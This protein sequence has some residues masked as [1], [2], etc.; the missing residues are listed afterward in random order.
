M[1]NTS[2]YG[3]VAVNN[4]NE[5]VIFKN[6]APFTYCITEMNNTKID[7]AQKID[8]V[9]PMYDLIEYSDAYSKTSWS[10]RQHYRDETALNA[11]DEIIHFPAD[12]NNIASFKFKQQITGHTE[13]SGT[14][15]VRIID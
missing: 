9:M 7:D 6:C 12:D 5:K 14:K 11:I 10:L 8:T 2:K 15:N 3:A 1:H 13:S 4:A